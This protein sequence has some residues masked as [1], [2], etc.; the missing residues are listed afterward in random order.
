MT[1]KRNLEP[2]ELCEFVD[3]CN[4]DKDFEFI[5]DKQEICQGKNP[6]RNTEFSCAL[7]RGLLMIRDVEKG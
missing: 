1:I 4:R 2:F 7:R 5:K 3:S 6:D